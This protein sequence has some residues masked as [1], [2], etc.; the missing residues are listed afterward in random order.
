[1]CGASTKCRPMVYPFRWLD[2]ALRVAEARQFDVL[3]PTHEQAAV[4]AGALPRLEAVGV[5]TA[6]PSID[7]LARVQDKLAARGH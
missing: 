4:L 2:A 6:V 1:M 3:V 5:R 7:A